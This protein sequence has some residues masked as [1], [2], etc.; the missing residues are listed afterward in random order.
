MINFDKTYSL[1]DYSNT[2]KGHFLN[3]QIYLYLH[4]ESINE[5]ELI[6]KLVKRKRKLNK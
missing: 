3:G 4:P 2:N 6:I 1:F 5:N